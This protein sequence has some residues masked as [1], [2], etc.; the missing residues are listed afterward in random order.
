MRLPVPLSHRGPK[1]QPQVV[2]TASDFPSRALSA[3]SSPT[4]LSLDTWLEKTTTR[5]TADD[6]AIIVET[7]EV[8]PTASTSREEDTARTPRE[9]GP[10]AST[11]REKEADSTTTGPSKKR[12]LSDT[13]FYF[14]KV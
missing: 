8:R 14:Y 11:S 5:R 3:F 4:N 7:A 1:S 6:D 12:R 10:T 13:L 2:G 9:E